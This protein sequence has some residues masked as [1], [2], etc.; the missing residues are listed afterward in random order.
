MPAIDKVIHERARLLIMTYLASR[1]KGEV[2]FNE[3]QEQLDLTPGNL[4]VQLK[5]LQSA[6]YV[7]IKKTFRENKPYTTVAS[8]A[9]GARA[10]RRYVSEMESL[11]KTLKKGLQG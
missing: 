9:E 7:R 6:G 8:T 11:I 1:G 3:L 4:S 10:I 2:S 5:R